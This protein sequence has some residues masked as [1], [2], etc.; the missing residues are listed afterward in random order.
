MV[1]VACG[2]GRHARLFLDLGFDV[3]AID[4]DTRRVA[5][6]KDN[7]R[8][9]IIEA[10][11]ERDAPW[12]LAGKHFAAVVVTNYLHRPLLPLLRDAV[13][14]GGVFI[15]ETFAEGN[16][17]F[18]Q[19]RNPNHLLTDGELLERVHGRLNVVAYEH[20]ITEIGGEPAVVQRIVAVNGI[21]KPKR[22][23]EPE[24][25]PLRPPP[26]TPPSPK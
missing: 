21:R 11:L 8:T 12:P 23:R 3:T 6:L 17:R 25:R 1:D 9:E 2:S 13:A 26:R 18:R 19:P 14:S 16:E 7:P 24:P 20:G 15:Y 10:D 5:D 22:G 4:S